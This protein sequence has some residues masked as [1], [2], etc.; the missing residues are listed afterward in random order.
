[1]PVSL[2][3]SPVFSDLYSDA[4][5]VLRLDEDADLLHM[6]RF[7]QALAKVQ[8]ALGIIPE[9]AAATIVSALETSE[10]EPNALSNGTRSA[11]IPV[12]ALVASLRK[13]AGDDAGS[14]LH[15]GATSQDVMDTALVLQAKS[16]LDVLE[17]RLGKLIDTLETESV[18]H[19]N[20]LLAGRTRSQI[21]TPVTF[22]YRIAQWAHGPID[23]EADLPDLRKKVLKIQ[24][25]G[26]S[27]INGAVVPDGPR[28]AEA[29]AR[30]LK[31]HFSSSWHTNRSNILALSAW[32]QAL[33][34]GLA[35]MAG[36]LLLLGRSDIAEVS[37]GTGG[38]SSTMPQKANPV[39]AEAILTLN[40]IV[41]TSAGGISAAASPAEERDGARWPLEWAFLPQMLIATGAALRHAQALA[42]SMSA[43]PERISAGFKNHPEIMAEAASFALAKNGVPRAEAKDIVAKAASQADFKSTLKELA[44][45]GIDWDAVLDPATVIPACKEMTA[46][47]FARRS[48]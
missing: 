44:P 34:A 16:C 27:G 22:G 8:G 10:I 26:A 7:E 19:A 17:E 14:W 6:I 43:N 15:W 31:L 2:F 28:I 35:K 24:F 42:D 5:L 12:P 37:S 13:I 38:G 11:G 20:Q 36:D 4:D 21:S 23:A 48:R 45:N 25:G 39:Q 30:E 1:M 41:Q 18:R 9:G 32:L 33:T 3:S 47:I 29:L 46:E 40:T